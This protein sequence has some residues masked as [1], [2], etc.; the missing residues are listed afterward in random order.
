MV[1]VVRQRVLGWCGH[2]LIRDEGDWMKGRADGEVEVV[3][4]LETAC[5]VWRG[6]LE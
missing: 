5:G 6:G 1:A 2:V 3:W 4:D